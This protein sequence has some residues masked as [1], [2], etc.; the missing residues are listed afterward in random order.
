LINTTIVFGH[1]EKMRL[2][3]GGGR[4]EAG[5]GREL[6]GETAVEKAG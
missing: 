1:A 6:C 4:L 2:E 5:G 3:A